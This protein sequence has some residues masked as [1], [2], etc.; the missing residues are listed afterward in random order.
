MFKALMLNV[1]EKKIAGIIVLIL[2]ILNLVLLFFIFVSDSGH[3][4]RSIIDGNLDNSK[5]INAENSGNENTQVKDL[6]NSGS[7]SFSVNTGTQSK[8]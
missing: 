5:D 8:N 2:I 3:I 4:S 6:S 7:G 1:T